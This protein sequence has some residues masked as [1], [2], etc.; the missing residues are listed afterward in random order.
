MWQRVQ[1]LYMAISTILIAAMLLSNEAVCHGA[2]GEIIGS[3]GFAQKLSHLILLIIILILNIL[4]LTV[5][6]HR[7]FQM[8]T[9]VLAAIVTLALQIWIAAD[10]ISLH[11]VFVFK[12]PAV[13]PAVCIILDILAARA[14]LADQLL[15]DSSSSLR[16]S[17]RERRSKR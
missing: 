10:F 3:I 17:R 1:T 7:V 9:A 12:L 13:F 11:E 6:S 2:D 8:R 14:I 5:I 16:K 15:V 4:A